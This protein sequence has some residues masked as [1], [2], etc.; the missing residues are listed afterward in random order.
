MKFLPGGHSTFFG[1]LNASVHVIMYGY[2]CLA[3]LGPRYQKFLWWKKYLTT[4]QMIQ[5]C[6]IMIHA[7]QLFFI[8]CD[9]PKGLAYYI[10]C[11]AIGFFCL[12]SHFY[13]KTYVN[14]KQI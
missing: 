3:A 5:F 10:G 12:F 2:Y 4:I 11:H 8:D 9:Y 7:F 13:K 14:K 6:L 1:M